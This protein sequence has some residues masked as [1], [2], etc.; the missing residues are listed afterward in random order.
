[1]SSLGT[2]IS[3]VGLEDRVSREVKH[4]NRR[5]GELSRRGARSERC[6]SFKNMDSILRAIER[7]CR[8]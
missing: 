5:S 8:I 3:S 6:S 7:Y 2:E 1:M 4:D